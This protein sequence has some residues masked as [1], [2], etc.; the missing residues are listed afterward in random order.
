MPDSDERIAVIIRTLRDEATRHEDEKTRVYD[1]G[2]WELLSHRIEALRRA[3]MD[4]EP[5]I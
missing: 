4:L 1:V 5:L 3:V 2:R